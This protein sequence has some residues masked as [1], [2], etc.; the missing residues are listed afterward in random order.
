V[1]QFGPQWDPHPQPQPDDYRP[2]V[3]GPYTPPP[4]PDPKRPNR[5]PRWAKVVAVALGA[6]VIVAGAFLGLFTATTLA[7]EAADPAPVLSSDPTYDPGLY[8]PEVPRFTPNT[9][10]PGPKA[11]PPEAPKGLEGGGLLIVGPDVE[12]GVYRSVVV[13]RYLAG[14]EDSGYCYVSRLNTTRPGLSDVRT[15]YDHVPTGPI[16]ADA[17]YRET[18][19]VV[20]LKILAT[21]KAVEIDCGDAQWFRV[22]Q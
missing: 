3:P 7:Q 14:R 5:M 11:R 16:I 12:P 4:T 18:G 19:Q 15:A 6:P 8:T 1:N 10:K 17:S 9:H 21:D 20:T 2:Q 13:P 22:D